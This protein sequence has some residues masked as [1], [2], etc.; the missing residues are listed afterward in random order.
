MIK[1]I[2]NFIFNKHIYKKITDNI[3][4]GNKFILNNKDVYNNIEVIINC[5]KSIPFYDNSKINHRISIDNDN[6]INNIKDLESY[7]EMAADIIKIHNDQ[8]KKILIHCDNSINLSTTILAA[9][10]IKY[11]KKNLYDACNFIIDRHPLAFFYEPKYKISLINY[12]Y[13]IL[14]KNEKD[15]SLIH[16]KKFKKY[17]ISL[18]IIIAIIIILIRN[19]DDTINDKLI[20]REFLE[21]QPKPLIYDL[22]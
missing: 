3:Y 8:N 12:E 16:L 5:S 20:N 2:I 19:K 14:K 18:I 13:N 6:N 22:R 4:I 10:F 1:D 11:E 7:L 17:W 15:I 21:I 9:Y